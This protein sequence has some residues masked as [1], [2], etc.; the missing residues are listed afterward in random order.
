MTNASEKSLGLLQ[1]GREWSQRRQLG[2]AAD[3]GVEPVDKADANGR[4]ALLA[5][6]KRG[7][8]LGPDN[9]AVG[10]LKHNQLGIVGNM[11]QR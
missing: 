3:A 11:C 4:N 6:Q 2:S 10:G 9:R 5:E 1:P 7:N 8:R